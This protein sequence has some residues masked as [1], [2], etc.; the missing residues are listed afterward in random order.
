MD[1]EVIGLVAKPVPLAEK[2]PDLLL[3]LIEQFGV[4]D[5]DVDRVN[6]IEGVG[7]DTSNPNRAGLVDGRADASSEEL[8]L[9]QV[10]PTVTSFPP[11][12]ES[13]SR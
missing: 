5:L 12:K 9:H 13:G 3:G 10:P 6:V 7:R 8:L 4:M 1:R 2:L 11:A